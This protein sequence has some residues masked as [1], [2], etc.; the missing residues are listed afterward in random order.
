MIKKILIILTFI[1]LVSLSTSQVDNKAGIEY[2]PYRTYCNV[3]KFAY[4]CQQ[5]ETVCGVTEM[6]CIRAP[7]YP[8]KKTY[9]SGCEACHTNGVTYYENGACP[10]PK[11]PVDCKKFVNKQCNCSNN[12]KFSCAL[13]KNKDFLMY[14]LPS[15]YYKCPCEACKDRHVST[16]YE[17][18]CPDNEH[19]SNYKLTICK[20]KDRNAVCTREYKGVCAVTA[21]GLQEVATICTG[22]SREDVFAVYD[23]KCSDILY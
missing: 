2:T 16:V 22:C 13:M 21:E 19:L 17:G 9:S 23:G 10:K 8:I 4:P 14:S 20:D 1:A 12:N 15:E 7:C 5:K 18:L 11:E 6:M 3:V